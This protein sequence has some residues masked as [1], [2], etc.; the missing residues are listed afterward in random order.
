M[1]Q[2]QEDLKKVAI[3]LIFFE[4]R[5]FNYYTEKE[6]NILLVGGQDDFAE[7]FHTITRIDYPD[8]SSAIRVVDK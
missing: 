5:S 4:F 8:K 2:D 1:V 3:N 7:E 6:N